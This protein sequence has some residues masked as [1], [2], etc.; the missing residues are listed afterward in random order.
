MGMERIERIGKI[1]RETLS[2]R[3]Y[4]SSLLEA[5]CN[6][7]LLSDADL[8]GIQF[9]CLALLARK[10][11]RYT[12]GESSS[13]PVEVAEGI[14][15][16]ILY[17]IGLSL[18]SFPCPDDAIFQL[19]AQSLEE[20]YNDGRKRIDLKIRSAKRLHRLVL[21]NLIHTQNRT[22]R[23][24]VV[25]GIKGFFKIYDADFRAD[26][27]CI[28]CDYP[29][30]TPLPDLAG[31]EFIEKYLREIYYENRFCKQFPT[32]AI[33]HLLCGYDKNYKE[34]IFN[35][36]QQVFTSAIGCVLAKTDL[37]ALSVSAVQV[38]QIHSMLL[39][40]LQD[41]TNAILTGARDALTA[42]LGLS[43][44]LQGTLKKAQPALSAAVFNAVQYDTLNQ[45]FVQPYYPE[46][47]P[48]IKFS[49]GEKMDNEKYRALISELR[50]CR[51]G[52]DKL[53][54]IREVVHAL[55]D[56]EDL[57]FDAELSE[58]EIAAVLD[59]LDAAEIAAL[60]KRHTYEAEALDLDEKE[61]QFRAS[62]DGYV[63]SQQGEKRA[64]IDKYKLLIK[65]EYDA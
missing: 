63:R 30:C 21:E 65:E 49:L 58:T 53:A 7:A 41:D 27:I 9:G 40:K 57:F 59:T 45:L 17:T 31:I 18:K 5:A 26:D 60:V 3:H 11:E 48:Q 12:N 52:D 4:F 1:G 20:I 56:L 34:L 35:I 2:E 13:V 15:Q 16:S 64:L 61:L 23:E 8:E 32:A 14:L 24:T 6:S 46:L 39:C 51:Y 54:L 38:E 19:K 10:T 22:Y 62:L 33:H 44:G 29:V 25:D 47:Y 36:F 42:A 37:R 28:T 55:A 50:Q 43:Q